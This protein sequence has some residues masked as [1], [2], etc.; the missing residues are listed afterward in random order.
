MADNG[1]LVAIS[2]SACCK[3]HEE[4]HEQLLYLESFI[5]PVVIEA[6]F[7][8][9]N[10]S[11]VTSV[12]VAYACVMLMSINLLVGGYSVIV[13]G[14]EGDEGLCCKIYQE[15]CVHSS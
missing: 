12:P 11:P 13:K 4:I 15:V 9:L 8:F 5:Q 1:N 10:T 3:L 14:E 6:C 7:N 2:C